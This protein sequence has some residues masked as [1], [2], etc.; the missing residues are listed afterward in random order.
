MSGDFSHFIFSSNSYNGFPGAGPG[1]IFA[2]GGLN[3]GPGSAYDNDIGDRTVELISKTESGENIPKFGSIPSD[4]SNDYAME[5]PGVSTD[6]SHVLLSTKNG[7]NY[8][9]YMRVGG[10]QG[11]TY[12]VT[13][14]GT[15]ANEFV[16]MT[17]NGS[18]VLFTT[19]SPLEADDKDT[20]VDLYVWKEA[21]DTLTRLSKAPGEQAL[22][23]EGNKNACGATWTSACNVKPVEPER[24]WATTMEVPFGN[25]GVPFL[26]ARGIDDVFAEGSGDVYFYSPEQLD[27]QNF[28]I[29]GQR[30]LYLYRNGTVKLVAIF[31]TGTQI[32][33]MQISADGSHAAMLTPS[34][35][36]SY[37]NDGFSQVYTYAADTAAI[38][39]ASCLPSGQPPTADAVTSQGGPFMADD[40]RTFFTTKD[41]LVPRDNNGA[42]FDVYEYVDGRP[43]LISSG[44]SA[45]D[46]T[47]Q[48]EVLGLFTAPEFTG[49]E[50][51]SRDGTDVYFST[52]DTLV[53]SDLNGE[54]VKFYDARA[55]GGFPEDPVLAPCAAADECHGVDS[56]PPAA[57]AV[58]SGTNLGTSGNVKAPAKKKA[59]KKKKKRKHKKKSRR[60]HARHH[61][62]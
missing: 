62:G 59:K 7:H 25:P 34:N 18:Q 40:G 48:S 37:D 56:S 52:F 33:R 51:V 1:G 21:T 26:S 13:P 35:L 49:L 50:S 9:L 46:F 41:R 32:E 58:M 60:K 30:N 8:R 27:P 6:G 45:R 19:A 24:R 43:Q 38:R 44:L 11:I 4:P 47:G 17:R 39:C 55:S 22:G 61:H 12:E 14:E 54:F 2:P 36:T 29:P 53:K 28:G 42:I 31:D 3:T 20:S 5:I 15:S 57:P 10:G 23:K 16:G